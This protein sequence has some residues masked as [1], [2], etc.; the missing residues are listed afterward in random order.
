M[1]LGELL[2]ENEMIAKARALPKER[3]D[4]LKA[5]IALHNRYMPN[6]L[7]VGEDDG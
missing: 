5:A 4:I 2:P 3:A 6:Q 7:L 1:N